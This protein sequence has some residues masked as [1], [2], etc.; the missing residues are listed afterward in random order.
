M[1]DERAV[2]PD[3]FIDIDIFAVI[4]SFQIITGQG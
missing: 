1:T 4:A 2:Y 3:P